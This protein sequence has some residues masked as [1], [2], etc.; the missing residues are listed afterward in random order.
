MLRLAALGST[1]MAAKL[2]ALFITLLINITVGA[3]IFAFML[4]AMNGYSE[5]DATWGLATFL[6][7]GIVVTLSMSAAAYLAVQSMIKRNFN[8][9]VSALI[10]IPIFSVTGAGLKIVCSF[11]GVSISEYIRTHY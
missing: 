1:H 3:A 2:A 8:A 9:A 4:L 11:I 5:S 7:L 6:V 10:A